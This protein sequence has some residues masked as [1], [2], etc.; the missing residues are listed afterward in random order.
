[1]KGVLLAAAIA[2]AAVPD[3]HADAPGV[4][5]MS[6]DQVVQKLEGLGYTNVRKLEADDGHWEADASKGGRS[7][8]LHVDP[9]SGQ[10]TKNEVKNHDDD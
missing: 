7:Y 6:K 3:A 2:F 4:D 5:W 1:M 8:E 9:H 10:L